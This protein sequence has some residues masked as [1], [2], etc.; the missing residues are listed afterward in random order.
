[1]HVDG[2]FVN[3]TGHRKKIYCEKK[4]FGKILKIQPTVLKKEVMR[5]FKNFTANRQDGRDT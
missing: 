4:T 5:V 3:P 2:P 1:V